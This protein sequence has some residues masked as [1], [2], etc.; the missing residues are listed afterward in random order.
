MEIMFLIFLLVGVGITLLHYVNESQVNKAKFNNLWAEYDALIH[1][2][3][4][5]SKEHQLV[6][7]E[8][9]LIK[10]EY[11]RLKSSKPQQPNTEITHNFTKSELQRIRFSVHPDKHQ[12]KTAQLF[13]KVNDMLEK[14][15]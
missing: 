14:M 4:A 9:K 6:A 10:A 5:I 11:L 15:K 1:V 7:K 2:N 13:I 12:G 8:L 3:Q